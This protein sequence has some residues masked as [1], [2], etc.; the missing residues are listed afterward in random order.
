MDRCREPGAR[1]AI[2]VD[3]GDGHLLNDLRLATI[4]V[5]HGDGHCAV[6]TAAIRH[7][8]LSFQSQVGA[9]YVFRHASRFAD[10][11]VNYVQR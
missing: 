3:F 2:V 6:T 5:A 10:A 9:Y 7:H 4:V 1:R 11:W 8:H